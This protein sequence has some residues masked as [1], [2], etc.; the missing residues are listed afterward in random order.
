[1]VHLFVGVAV[2]EDS[3]VFFLEKFVRLKEMHYLCNAKT[4]RGQTA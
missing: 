2:R 3:R 4:L 1:M